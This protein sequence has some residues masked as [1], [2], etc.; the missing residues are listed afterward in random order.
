[1]KVLSASQISENLFK[2]ALEKDVEKHDQLVGG[3]KKS[4]GTYIKGQEKMQP[5]MTK[6]MAIA[7][8]FVGLISQDD[9]INRYPIWIRPFIITVNDSLRAMN[10]KVAQEEQLTKQLKK[11]FDLG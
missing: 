9:D 2:T 3:I 6:L 11:Y 8:D 7:T 5:D 4:F 1:M 10:L